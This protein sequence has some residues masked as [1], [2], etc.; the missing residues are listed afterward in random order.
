[1]KMK[2]IKQ[3]PFG[4]VYVINKRKEKKP[5]WFCVGDPRSFKSRKVS[6]RREPT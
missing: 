2:Q 4:C 5:L 1:M 6:A 3:P